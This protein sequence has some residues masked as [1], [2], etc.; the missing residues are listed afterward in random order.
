MALEGIEVFVKVVDEESFSG[1]ARALEVSKSHVSKQISRLEDRLGAR[2]LHRTTRQVTLTDIGRAFYERSARI[3]ADVEE[4]ELAVAELQ[5]APRGLLRM[6]APMAFGFTY[7]APL[8]AEFM[9]HHADLSVDLQ[10]GDRLVDMVDEGFDLAVRIGRLANSSLIARR[11]AGIHMLTV[12]S[13]A[14]LAERGEPRHP[15][16]LAHHRCLMYTNTAQPALW[17]FTGPDGDTEVRVDG[18][19]RAN[20]GEALCHGAA[21]GLGIVRLPDWIAADALRAGTLVP[22]LTDWCDRRGGIHAVY[23]HNRHLSPKVRLMVDFLAER[24]AGVLPWALGP[25]L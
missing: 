1:A 18:P 24:F 4:A 17:S 3:L 14:Y 21:A 15:R 5:T 9:T 20:N 10:L 6:A 16:E 2:L 7:L 11:L 12:A 19:L 23:P 13:P 22:I 25:A 8:V